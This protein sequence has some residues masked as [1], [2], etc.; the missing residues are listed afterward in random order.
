MLCGMSRTTRHVALASL[1]A[2][3]MVGCAAAPDAQSSTS[4]TS[5]DAA[6]SAAI[7]AVPGTAEST[8]TTETGATT[9]DQTTGATSNSGT[10]AGASTT[11]ASGQ[12]AAANPAPAAP[13]NL[14]PIGQGPN[15]ENFERLLMD[16]IYTYETPSAET[17]QS[18]EA[19]L[20][21][22][23]ATSAEDFAVAQSIVNNWNTV[24]A[25]P[26]Y[27]LCMYG[28]GDQATELAQTGLR[29][30]PTHAFVVLGYELV[31]GE[32]TEELQSRC[33][34]AAAAARSFP[35]AIIVCSG[36]ATGMNNPEGHTEA[37]VMRDYLVQTCGID[38]TRIHIDETA[39][40]TAQN[41]TNTFQILR[42][43]GIQTITVV[44]SSYHQ[45]WV[46]AVLNA[47]AALSIRDFG[48]PIAITGNYSVD[49]PLTEIAPG[50]EDRVAI[51]QVADVLGLPKTD[52]QAL[53]WS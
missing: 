33:D 13:K 21:A 22:I 17:T 1:L 39:Q 32:M 26:N 51:E 28:G 42:N 14:V 27:P 11:A 19:D 49:Y 31:N 38:P 10:G 44:T 41:A 3:S 29:D 7:E 12:N 43:Q 53:M 46:Q 8:A 40:D 37:G 30:S 2:F 4:G 45:G 48:A 18:L 50:T 9:P 24:F 47:A 23:Q 34:A 6:E 36:G 35:S 15:R 52:M 25:N 5:T 16:L 20:A